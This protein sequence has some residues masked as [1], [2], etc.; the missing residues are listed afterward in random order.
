M[1]LQEGPATWPQHDDAAGRVDEAASPMSPWSSSPASPPR[2]P[3][4]PAC[5]SSDAARASPPGWASWPGRAHAH[6]RCRPTGARA[7]PV[8]AW[9][10]SGWW[11]VERTCGAFLGEEPV[12]A[13]EKGG[14]G[15]QQH[16]RPACCFA[17]LGSFLRWLRPAGSRRTQTGECFSRP[18]DRAGNCWCGRSI[19]ER[20]FPVRPRRTIP[21]RQAGRQGHWPVVLS[22]R[23]HG[24]GSRPLPAPSGARASPVS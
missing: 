15:S 13:A 23:H 4:Q 19:I 11:S 1:V 20:T 3:I 21:A 24:L 18:G 17:R 14:L 5:A 22:D 12:V 10:G 8:P 9:P 16:R 7:R 6:G 2:D